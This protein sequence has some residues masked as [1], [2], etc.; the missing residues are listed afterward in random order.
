MLLVGRL[1]P[2]LFM[3]WRVGF[4]NYAELPGY[5][6]NFLCAPARGLLNTLGAA[7]C[8]PP[9]ATSKALWSTERGLALCMTRLP[10]G[11]ARK[12]GL[13]RLG[14]LGLPGTYLADELIG[15]PRSGT[16]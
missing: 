12:R 9:A 3:K 2:S 6:L 11:A 13:G 8:C 14:W 15:R 1:S 4:F 10:V 16:C 5:A 7:V